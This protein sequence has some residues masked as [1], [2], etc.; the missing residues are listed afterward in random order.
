M[1]KLGRLIGYLRAASNQVI[2]LRVGNK[3]I[4]RAYI[5]ATYGGHQGSEKSH[6]GCAV[7]LGDAGVLDARSAKAEICNEI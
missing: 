5:D 1:G 3:M 4:V 6:T 2:I 7:F